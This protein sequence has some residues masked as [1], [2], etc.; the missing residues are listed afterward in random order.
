[1]TV[2][3]KSKKDFLSLDARLCRHSRQGRRENEYNVISVTYVLLPFAPHHTQVG[4]GKRKKAIVAFSNQGLGDP[5]FYETI[6]H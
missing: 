2:S 4:E 6:M 5:I 1:M 3:Q